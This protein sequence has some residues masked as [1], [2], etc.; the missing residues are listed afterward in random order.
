MSGVVIEVRVKEG[1]S[2]KAGDVSSLNFSLSFLSAISF[3][4]TRFFFFLLAS[5]CAFRHEDGIGGVRPGLWTG[6]SGLG[7]A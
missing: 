4:L 2:I 7:P 1:Q 5:R 6:R 3:F